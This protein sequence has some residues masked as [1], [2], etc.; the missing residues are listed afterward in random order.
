MAGVWPWMEGRRLACGDHLGKLVVEVGDEG[1]R[2]GHWALCGL[3][4]LLG[5][6]Q[7]RQFGQGG[8]V[9]TRPRWKQGGQCLAGRT[10][11]HPP[12]NTKDLGYGRGRGGAWQGEARDLQPALEGPWC[13]T[14]LMVDSTRLGEV[15]TNS[16]CITAAKAKP[17]P[18]GQK[19]WGQGPGKRHPV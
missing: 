1:T 13:L 16:L 18:A 4:P 9:G 5:A 7:A 6:G 8:D 11:F 3:S 10:G 2:R 12:L 19:G 14:W 17:G 15:G